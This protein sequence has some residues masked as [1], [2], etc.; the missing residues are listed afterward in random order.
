MQ[1]TLF[2]SSTCPI[3]GSLK[4][5]L[6]GKNVPFTEKMIDLSEDAKK[7]MI[8]ASGGFMGVPYLVIVKNDGTTEN[9]IGFDKGKINSLLGLVK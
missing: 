3:C 8:A 2:T 6:K 1:I 7:E 9:V 4:D 5:Y